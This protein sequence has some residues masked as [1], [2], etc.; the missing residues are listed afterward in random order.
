MEILATHTD[1]GAKIV[2]LIIFELMALGLWVI[3]F[4]SDDALAFMGA[5]LATAFVLIGIGVDAT[6]YYDAIITDW[7]VVHDQGYEVVETNGK[8]VTLRKVGD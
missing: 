8:I 1:I 2:V 5:T 7:N 3:A 6:T 4:E